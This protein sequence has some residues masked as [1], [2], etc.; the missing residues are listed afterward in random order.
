MRVY[1]GVADHHA[2][3][4]VGAPK[5]AIRVRHRRGV[6]AVF[7]LGSLGIRLLGLLLFLLNMAAELHEINRIDWKE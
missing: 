6:D 1:A 2:R 4:D 5:I 3:F 7:C